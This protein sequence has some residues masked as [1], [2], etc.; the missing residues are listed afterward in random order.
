MRR[1]L[2]E[3]TKSDGSD[4]GAHLGLMFDVLNT[5]EGK[6]QSTMPDALKALPY[7]NGGMFAKPLPAV[8]GTRAIRDTLMKCVEFNWSRISPAIFGSM[9]QS[10]MDEKQRHDLGAHYTS[11]TNIL[12]VINGLFLE[13]LKDELKAATNQEKLTALWDKVSAITLLDPAC[14]CGNFLVIAYRELRHLELE[15]IKRVH[16]HGAAKVDAGHTVLPIGTDASKISRLSIEQMYGIEIEAFPAE[17]AR[18]SLWL[19]DHMMNIEL[20]TYFGKPFKKIPITEQPHIVQGDALQT[21][22]ETIVSKEK[23]THILG[24]P[25]FLGSRIMNKEQKEEMHEVFGELSEVGFLDYVAAWYMKA[26]KLIHG[27]SIRCAFVSTNSISQG[28]QAGILWEALKPY[29]ISIHFAHRTF[30]WS[31]EATGKAAVYCVIIGFAAF[32]TT[33]PRL[34]DY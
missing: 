21:D 18:L 14:G 12:K 6:R 13:E 3:N 33:K 16:K 34:F 5:P 4:I 19:M 30:K 27:T 26:A 22:W 25:P 10:V 24:N 11:E 2:E 1:Y 32:S 15:I 31:N 20:G 29:D 17:V 23:L 9:F 8:F 28:E 7:V